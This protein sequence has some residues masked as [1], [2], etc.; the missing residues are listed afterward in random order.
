M[1]DC[2]TVLAIFAPYHV[3]ENTIP[4]DQMNPPPVSINDPQ[5]RRDAEVSATLNFRQIDAAPE[6]VLNQILWRS[7]KGSAVPYPTWAI[8]V[9]EDDDDELPIL[10]K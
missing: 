7:Q 1:F 6:D 8:T 5:L 2:F 10:V 3:L 4:L 9:V